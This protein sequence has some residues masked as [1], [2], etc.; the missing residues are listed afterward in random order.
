MQ[1]AILRHRQ[2]NEILVTITVNDVNEPPVV[3]GDETPEVAENGSLTVAAYSA[4]DPENSTTSNWSLDGDD[5]NAFEISN[6]GVL[7]FVAIPDYEIQGEYSVTVQNSD[8]LLTGWLA[9]TV[10]ITN[11][12]ERGEIELSS[13][14][15]QVGTALTATLED[16]DGSLA[17]IAWEWDSYSAT[18]STWTTVSTTT[19]GSA[20]SNA[21]TPSEDDEGNRTCVSPPRTRTVTPPARAQSSSPA[22]PFGLRHP[23]QPTRQRSHCP[24]R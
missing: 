23:G 4:D 6:S 3:S 10:T 7:S 21:Y 16:D 8:G 24:L 18:T 20:T 17:D 1:T 14:Q 11:I 2:D 13:E 9:V 5:K 12:D 22:I 15:P 19:A